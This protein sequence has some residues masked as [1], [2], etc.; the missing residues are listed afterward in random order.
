[1]MFELCFHALSLMFFICS[2]FLDLSIIQGKKC[3]H[4]VFLHV[5]ICKVIDDGNFKHL[6]YFS[7]SSSTK[8]SITR[9]FYPDT[10]STVESDNNM[11]WFDCINLEFCTRS[12]F[13]IAQVIRTMKNQRETR[14]FK[15]YFKH[16]FKERVFHFASCLLF[17][18]FCK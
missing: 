7:R 1:M 15:F 10:H 16:Y 5:Y 13:I 3:H 8:N 17:Y 2:L 14:K 6:T 12:V 18:V 4:H 11:P 9:L